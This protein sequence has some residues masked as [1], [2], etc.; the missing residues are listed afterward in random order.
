[1]LKFR[2]HE[3]LARLQLLQEPVVVGIV[4]GIDAI[5]ER[6]RMKHGALLEIDLLEHRVKLGVPSAFVSVGPEDDGRMVVVALQKHLQVFSSEFRPDRFLPAAEFI[7]NINSEF[8]A[9][10]EERFV[11]REVRNPYRVHVERLDE[12]GVLVVH[13]ARQRA[14]RPRVER[15][16]IDT[17][18]DNLLPVD[19]HTVARP[20]F[21]GSESKPLRDGINHIPVFVLQLENPLVELRMVDIPRLDVRPFLINRLLSTVAR[22]HDRM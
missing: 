4:L 3:K 19:I 16:A 12:P 17:F 8:V 18:D 2:R 1:M 15:L 9:G 13:L 5:M 21:D 11:R 14:P 7:F 6:P 20:D 10:I 22:P